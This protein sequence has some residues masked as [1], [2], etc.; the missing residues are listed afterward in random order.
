MGMQLY[1]HFISFQI[2]YTICNFLNKHGFILIENVMSA[3]IGY[4]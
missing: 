4:K 3:I 2:L 1:V